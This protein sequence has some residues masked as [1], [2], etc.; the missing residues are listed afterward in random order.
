MH[1]SDSLTLVRSLTSLNRGDYSSPREAGEAR[2][3]ILRAEV[4]KV[5]LSAL[6]EGEG[7]AVLASWS[8]LIGSK[9]REALEGSY[10]AIYEQKA[11]D[12]RQ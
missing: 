11:V 7:E 1:A 4:Q 8:E 2:R 6:S 5:G 12:W 10:Y 9:L 3:L